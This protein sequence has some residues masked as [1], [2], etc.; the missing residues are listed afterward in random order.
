ML[1]RSK[2]CR[3]T[4]IGDD[5]T[6]DAIYAGLY[7]VCLSCKKVYER[8]KISF[9]AVVNGKPFHFYPFNLSRYFWQ[10]SWAMTMP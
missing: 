2:Q 1:G 9:F 3:I 8:G 5:G 7:V 10:C 6:W 4:L